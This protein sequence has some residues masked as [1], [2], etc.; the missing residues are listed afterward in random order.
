MSVLDIVKPGVLSGSE[1]H[2]LF[3]YA[4]ENSF[5]IPA[6]NVIG[7]DSV[8][9]VLE[10]AAKVKSPIIIQFSNGGAGFFAG[11][12]L[13]D[14]KAAVYGGI[15]GAM[16]VHALA[17]AYGVPVILHT[18][19]AA[20]KLLPWIDGL[21]EAG[22]AFYSKHGKPLFKSHMLDLSEEFR[23]EYSYLCRVF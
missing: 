16:H 23:R 11:K 20:K 4:K 7:T 2:K 8:N 10:S 13:K 22:E 14:P 18:D 21:I 17:E 15:S 5:A 9:A 19:H 1:A 6:V 3:E 12:G